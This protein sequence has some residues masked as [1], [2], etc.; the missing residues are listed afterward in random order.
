MAIGKFL[1]YLILTELLMRVPDQFW[2]FF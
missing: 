2:Q 1:R